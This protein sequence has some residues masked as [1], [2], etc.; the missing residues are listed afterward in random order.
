MLILLVSQNPEPPFLFLLRA[1]RLSLL[2]SLW[3][4]EEIVVV[5]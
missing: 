4:P 3:L 2:R 1:L 5:L